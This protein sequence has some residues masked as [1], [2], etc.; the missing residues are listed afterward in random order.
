MSYI[1]YIHT[2][3]HVHTEREITVIIIVN[4]NKKIT[5]VSSRPPPRD[6]DIDKI[7][8][9]SWPGCNTND[10]VLNRSLLSFENTRAVF[11]VY[12]PFIPIGILIC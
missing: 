4:T 6:I 12:I 8:R 5:S 3:T 11:S 1:K 10:A 7:G 2:Y 9:I